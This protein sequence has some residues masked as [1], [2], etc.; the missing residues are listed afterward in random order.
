MPNK[1][2]WCGRL[3]HILL[4]CTASDD[5]LL[6]WTRAKRNLIVQKYGTP[7]GIA[8][9]VRGLLSDISRAYPSPHPALDVSAL[10]ECTD[11]YDDTEVS[12]PFSFV[13]FSPSFP[14]GRDLCQFWVVDSTYSINLTA[15]SRWRCQR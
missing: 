15:F 11:D 8:I 1:C 7:N 3:D 9:R 14:P 4:S 13:A 10:Q 12:V 2:S 6:K 5:A